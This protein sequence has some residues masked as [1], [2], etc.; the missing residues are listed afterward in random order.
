MTYWILD[1]QSKH[2]LARSVVRP[3]KNNLRVKWN[4]D[5][6]GGDRNTAKIADDRM[7][8]DYEKYEV[9]DMLQ[10]TLS[11]KIVLYKSVNHQY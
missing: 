5:L 4:P 11:T 9:L 6:M 3:F 8:A 1:D 2:I 10:R 7:P